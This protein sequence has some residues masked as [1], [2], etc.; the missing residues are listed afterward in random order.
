MNTKEFIFDL[1]GVIVD[2][3]KVSFFNLEKTSQ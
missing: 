1:D 3:E 2:I